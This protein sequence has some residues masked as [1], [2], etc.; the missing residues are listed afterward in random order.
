M[1]RLLMLSGMTAAVLIAN[2]MA[3][4]PVPAMKELSLKDLP[5]YGAFKAGPYLVAAAQLQAMGK[6]K[7]VATLREY[8]KVRDRNDS[9]KVRND[10]M[11]VIPLCRMLFVAKPKGDF[12][13][14]GLGIQFLGGGSWP[15]D[16]P[17]LPF[18]LVDGIPFHIT[19]GNFGTGAGPEHGR[20]YLDYCVQ[21]CDWNTE[22]FKPKTAEEIR[23]ALAK[24]LA[25]PKWREPLSEREKNWLKSQIE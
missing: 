6:E 8:A 9:M 10:S 14:P 21:N 4:D 16:W 7:A 3:A 24:L 13:P 1:K 20:E 17:L 18:E 5:E 25:S 12:R 15:S 22:A 11:K 23:K 19:F 2:G